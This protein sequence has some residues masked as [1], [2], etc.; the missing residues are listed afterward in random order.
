GTNNSTLTITGT[1]R[2]R[3]WE[4]LERN[5]KDM[6][7]ETDKLLPEGSSETFV[8]SRG[9]GQTA[10]TQTRTTPTRRG[11]SS[12]TSDTTTPPGAEQSAQA[13]EFAEQRLT[14]REAASVFVNPE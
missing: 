14:F 9:Q 1:A 2:H 8:Q 3:F 5:I 7:R 11:T 10:T 4:T 6:L 12:Q 13:Q